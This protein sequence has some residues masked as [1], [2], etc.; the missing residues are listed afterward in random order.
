[1]THGFE[2]YHLPDDVFLRN[3]VELLMRCDALVI[4]DTGPHYFHSEGTVAEVELAQALG[5]PCYYGV[6]GLTRQEEADA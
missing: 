5:V 6:E 4:V 1:M 2:M 3:G